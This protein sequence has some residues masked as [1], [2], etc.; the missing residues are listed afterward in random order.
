[1]SETLGGVAGVEDDELNPYDVG[2]EDDTDEEESIHNPGEDQPDDGEQPAKVG[3]G[4]F[5]LGR[6]GSS[7]SIGAHGANKQR[8]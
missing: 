6:V 8:G 5:G 3:G 7:I 2:H 1:M 4:G